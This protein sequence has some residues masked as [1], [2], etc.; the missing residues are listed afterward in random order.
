MNNI[1]YYN[2]N[3]APSVLDFTTANEFGQLAQMI[4]ENGGRPASVY[5]DRL[6]D[7]ALFDAGSLTQQ[8]RVLFSVPIGGQNTTL[9]GGATYQV[10]EQFTNMTN[11]QQLPAGN[12]FWAINMQVALTISGL[13]DNTVNSSGNNPGLASDPGL[14]NQI[15]AAD[16]I[17]ATNL[18]QVILE[19]L[20][21]T[22]T[23]NNTRFERGPALYFPT[24]YGM[25]G[26]AG[27]FA[28]VP[29]T[30]GTT[31][32]AN[33]VAVNNGLNGPV[34]FAQIRHIPAL[35]N[36]G[37]IMKVNN[38]FTVTRPFRVRV[39]FEGVRANAITA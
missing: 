18:A 7:T 2:P 3:S 5:T 27:G 16:A 30:A 32:A 23:L 4:A 11:A 37:V 33:E 14:E 26:F 12:E 24:R 9:V 10:G 39:I 35:Y 15:N 34:P 6:Y 31:I 29:G 36:F 28:Y 8:E 1:P 22:F 21:F 19:S 25:S 13:L 20:S 38:A 17:N